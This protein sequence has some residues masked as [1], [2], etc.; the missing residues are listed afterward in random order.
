MVLSVKRSARMVSRIWPMFSCGISVFPGRAA[1]G[2]PG[3][4]PGP[5][6]SRD[7][8]C[9]SETG[10]PPSISSPGCWRSGSGTGRCR[11]ASRFPDRLLA[12]YYRGR[13]SDHAV[14]RPHAI[15]G[16]LRTKL[17]DQLSCLFYMTRCG[18]SE[19]DRLNAFKF[20]YVLY[21]FPRA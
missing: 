20:C 12:G 5:S 10:R 17:S 8:E 19:Y 7:Q 13:W 4:Y 6:M 21:G 9:G 18:C 11:A 15:N 3:R 1:R 2:R 14:S 16:W